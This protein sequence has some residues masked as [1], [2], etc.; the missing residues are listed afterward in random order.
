MY[1]RIEHRYNREAER[2][3]TKEQNGTV[4]AF[5]YDQMGR[6]V[7]GGVLSVGDG[8]DRSL[9]RVETEYDVRSLP[10]K[11]TCY[12]SRDPGSGNLVNQLLLQYNAFL[13]LI[14][15]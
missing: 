12:D 6:R 13:L 11:L 2:V 15:Q 8:R 14:R 4:K 7:R 1:D 5:E 9:G 10:V 3:E